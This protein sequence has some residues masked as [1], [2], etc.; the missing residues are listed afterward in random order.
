MCFESVSGSR[1][2]SHDAFL[3]GGGASSVVSREEEKEASRPSRRH[4]VA[5]RDV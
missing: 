2:F 3:P 4:V 1:F 5:Q